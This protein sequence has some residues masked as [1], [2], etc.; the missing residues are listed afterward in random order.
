M[1]MENCRLPD[2][3]INPSRL[4]FA[5][6]SF[7]FSRRTAGVHSLATTLRENKHDRACVED[8]N[9]HARQ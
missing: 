1:E 3:L 8:R 6:E 4:G 7:F 9:P 5:V 2:I